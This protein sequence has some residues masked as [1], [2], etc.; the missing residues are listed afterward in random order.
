MITTVADLITKL[1][2]MPPGAPVV[3]WSEV[4]DGWEAVDDPEIVR[5]A[6]DK[7]RKVWRHLR[8]GDWPVDCVVL[9]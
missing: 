1:Q 9:G 7:Q 2:A 5:M 4:D 3:I 6:Y 8:G